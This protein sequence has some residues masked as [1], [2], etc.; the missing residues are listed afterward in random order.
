MKPRI[1]WLDD[2]IHKDNL[3]PTIGLFKR[4]FDIIECE[5]IDEFYKKSKAFEWDAAILDVVNA[6]DDNTDIFPAILHI[7]T[8]F[9]RKLWFI[10]SGKDRITKNENDIK[11]S[12]EKGSFVRSYVRKDIYIKDEDEEALMNDVNTAVSNSDVWRVENQYSD[13]LDIA[14]KVLGDKDCRKHRLDILC[15]AT[16]VLSIDSHLYFNRIRVILEWI[17]RAARKVGL[18]HDKCF[19]SQDK[20]NLTDASLFMAGKATTHSGVKCKTAHFP[21][22]IAN[23]VKS[24]LSITG[25]ASHTTVVEDKENMNLTAYW[26]EIDTPYLLYSLAFM[27]CDVIVWFDKYIN[28][29][30]DVRANKLLW[31]D[32][33][34][35]DSSQRDNYIVSLLES[36]KDYIGI[37]EQDSSG[38]FHVD[39]CLLSYNNHPPIGCRIQLLKVV[40]NN[41]P[42]KNQYPIFATTHKDLSSI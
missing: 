38:N 13:V 35:N 10:F 37:C 36:Y 34:L 6:K 16:G 4:K 25:G 20:I 41:K 15:A 40:E 22:L 8:S 3:R 42:N 33:D 5:T 14:D 11:K 9:P 21:Y 28:V 24:I 30:S 19:D 23:N 27:L 12:L 2:E 1:I 17:F 26:N 29:H 7:A 31:E 39:E 18:L 32:L